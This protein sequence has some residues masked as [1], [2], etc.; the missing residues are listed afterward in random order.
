MQTLHEKNTFN[1]NHFWNYVE[2]PSP[3]FEGQYEDCEIIAADRI[4]KICVF[5]PIT[6]DD[7][8]YDLCAQYFNLL[9]N[10]FKKMS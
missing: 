1:I 7:M 4:T 10:M 9:F 2:W 8:E 6:V 3:T 5:F